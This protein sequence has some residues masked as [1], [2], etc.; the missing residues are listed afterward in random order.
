MP[1]IDE[2]E[3]WANRPKIGIGNRKRRTKSMCGFVGFVDA[4]TENKDVYKRQGNA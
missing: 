1:I 2:D 4:Q 3:S